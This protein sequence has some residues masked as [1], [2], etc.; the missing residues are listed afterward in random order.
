M[1]GLALALLV[2]IIGP[3]GVSAPPSVARR[4]GMNGKVGRFRRRN[5]YEG[6]WF[7]PLTGRI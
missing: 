2:F 7:Y 3:L 1:P 6:T 4:I 5:R